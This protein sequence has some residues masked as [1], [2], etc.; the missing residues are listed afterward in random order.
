MIDSNLYL[1]LNNCINQNSMQKKEDLLN[2]SNRKEFN[3]GD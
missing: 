2:V 3:T 1:S